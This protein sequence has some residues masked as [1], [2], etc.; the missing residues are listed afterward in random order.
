MVINECKSSARVA[1]LVVAVAVIMY[2][3]AAFQAFAG[4]TIGWYSSL[5]III[6]LALLMNNM[7]LAVAVLDVILPTTT[8]KIMFG[9]AFMG[10][11]GFQLACRGQYN[12]HA[13]A[14]LAVFNILVLLYL[15]FVQGKLSSSHVQAQCQAQQAIATLI[16]N[17]QAQES[18]NVVTGSDT[19]WTNE[20]NLAGGSGR[21]GA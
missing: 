1:V 18:E 7:P 16:H 3:A 19:K 5:V 21:A 11:A 4:A 12:K 6:P 13:V 17:A 15:G 10:S 2:S 9:V 20:M 14:A 8:S